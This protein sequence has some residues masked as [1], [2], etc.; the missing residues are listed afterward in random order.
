MFSSLQ[1]LYVHLLHRSVLLFYLLHRSVL[2]FY[3]LHRSVLLFYLLHRSVLLFYVN[4]STLSYHSA[5]AQ[6]RVQVHF[7]G[8]DD[9][10]LQ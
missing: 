5:R 2:L 4:S 7:T 8:F 9:L 3:L 6:L 10:S 1:V